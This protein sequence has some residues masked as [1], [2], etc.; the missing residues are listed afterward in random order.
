MRRIAICDLFGFTV[1]SYMS[2]NGTICR[3][4]IM[5]HKMRVLIFT[6]N[7][8]FEEN[9]ARYYHKCTPVFTLND[10]ILVRF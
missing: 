2:K 10:G 7:S 1:F 9:I 3:E 6:K 5:E 4:K 8:P